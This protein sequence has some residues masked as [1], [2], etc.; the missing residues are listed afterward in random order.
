MAYRV[1][2]FVHTVLLL[3]ECG[4]LGI[5]FVKLASDTHTARDAHDAAQI[6]KLR[7]HVALTVTSS[8]LTLITFTLTITSTYVLSRL[9]MDKCTT[10]LGPLKRVVHSLKADHA[11]LSSTVAAECASTK[12]GQGAVD[13]ETLVR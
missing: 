10:I 4:I 13:V 9:S 6:Q 12:T 5:T 1:H 11:K 8:V 3:C 7:H 2:I